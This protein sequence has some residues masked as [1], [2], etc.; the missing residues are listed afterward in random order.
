MKTNKAYILIALNCLMIW[1]CSKEAES[2]IIEVELQVYF[3]TFVSEAATH[4][5][6]IDL[7]LLDIGG[8]VQNIE[9]AGTI[10]QC[11]SYSDGS[12]EVVLDARNW[13]R[14]DNQE[15]EYVVFH[16]LGHCILKR[17]HNDSQDN[18]GVCQSIMQSG[19]GLCQ[20]RYNLDNRPAML[21]ELFT[22]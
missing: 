13:D 3:D 20:N 11:I 8:Y 22:N 7:T 1:S 6:E 19:E 15:K 9:S 12:N 18:S 14:I 10:G 5:V 4:G 17:S 2:N 21:Q 16:E